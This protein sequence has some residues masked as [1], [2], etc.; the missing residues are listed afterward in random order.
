MDIEGKRVL[1]L[2]G[3]G[4]VG[5]AVCR[6]LLEPIHL[7][8]LL[9]RGGGTGPSV[10]WTATEDFPERLFRSCRHGVTCFSERNGRRLRDFASRGPGRHA[11]TPP[12]YRRYPGSARIKRLLTSSLLAQMI[13][14]TLPGLEDE[15]AQDRPRLHEYRDRSQLPE[16]LHSGS[17]LADG[18]KGSKSTSL[19][20]DVEVLLASLYIPQLV[21]HTNCCTRPC[22]VPA[23]APIS[24]SARPAPAEWG[25]TFPIRTER[26]NLPASCFRRP[27]SPGR[28]A[29]S[30][31]SW[32]EHPMHRRSSRRSSRPP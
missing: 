23:P 18:P 27:P 3:A 22:G 5:M 24:R 11:K 10:R 15:P 21:R 31:S 19:N 4:L 30:H 7:D 8:W 13:E 1:V 12:P 16:H 25:S 20:E 26:R 9:P 6:Q 29:C 32:P 14:G 28:K 2:G 17:D